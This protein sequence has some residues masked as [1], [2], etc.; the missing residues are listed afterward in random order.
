MI[1]ATPEPLEP[2]AFFPCP[3]CK[4]RTMVIETRPRGQNPKEGWIGRRRMCSDKGCAHRF[5]THELMCFT[6]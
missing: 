2:V 1:E 4:K 6:T 3:V 5:S